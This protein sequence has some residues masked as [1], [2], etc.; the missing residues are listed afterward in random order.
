MTTLEDLINLDPYDDWL[1]QEECGA[2]ELSYLHDKPLDREYQNSLSRL[3]GENCHY[4]PPPRS[5]GWIDAQ[6]DVG[7]CLEA[8]AKRGLLQPPRRRETSID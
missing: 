8:Q 3:R 4:S 5:D 2:S 7:K 6:L 1:D